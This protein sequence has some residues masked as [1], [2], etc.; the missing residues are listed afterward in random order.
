ME[1]QSSVL[2][3]KEIPDKDARISALGRVSL[4]CNVC[5]V[6]MGLVGTRSIVER[7]GVGSALLL[8]PL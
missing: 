3:A 8:L 4:A 1:Y 7:R 6:L 2:I 5:S